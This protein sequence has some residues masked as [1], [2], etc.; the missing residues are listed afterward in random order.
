MLLRFSTR[1][2]ACAAGL[3]AS[4][5]LGAA[6]LAQE[7]T[8]SA[9]PQLPGVTSEDD[10]QPADARSDET[11]NEEA[12]VDPQTTAPDQPAP[13]EAAPNPQPQPDPQPAPATGDLDR[14]RP[15]T[16]QDQI[17]TREEARD[18]R[19]DARDARDDRHE[20]IRDRADDRRDDRLDRRMNRRG[21]PDIGL[22]FSSTTAGALVIDQIG[23]RYFADAGFR[24]GDRIVSAAGR[25]FNAPAD[26]FVWLGT[27]PVGQ[28]VPIIVLRDGRETTVYWTPTAEF[29]EMYAQQAPSTAHFL[30]IHIDEQIEGAA[31]VARVDQNSPAERGGVVAGD[32]VMSVNNQ[33]VRSPREFA[34]AAA[35]VAANQPVRMAISRTFD[36]QLDPTAPGPAETRTSAPAR[37]APAVIEQPARQPAVVP[38]P[39]VRD[40]YQ[41]P[42][43]GGLFRRGR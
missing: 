20:D 10:D 40:D 17:D 23:P 21:S 27:V 28:R 16:N 3:A 34:D 39:R 19:D 30:G 31:V 26:F 25:R 33:E 35:T 37:P 13:S 5:L 15:T 7:P 9:N 43:R 6:A 24:R 8:P 29:V 22:T 11:S 18:A 4:G 14:D 36:V 2:R 41:A 42:R 12:P 1:A 38:Q 32:V